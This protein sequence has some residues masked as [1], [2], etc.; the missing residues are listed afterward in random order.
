MMHRCAVRLLVFALL[1]VSLPLV[2]EERILSYDSDI[3]VGADGDMTVRETI[4]V[5]AEGKNIRRGIYREFPTTY[6]D[7]FGNTVKVRFQIVELTRDGQTEPWHKQRLSNGVRIYAGS[8]DTFLSPGEYTYAFTYTTNRQIGFFE[9]HDELYWNVTGNGWDFAIERASATVRLPG[10]IDAA[11]ITL[12]GYTGPQGSK[13]RNFVSA[14]ADSS[15]TIQTSRALPPRSGLTLVMGWPK[16]VVAQPGRLQQLLYLLGDNFGLLLSVL[17]FIG[18]AAYLFV[19]WS[20]HGRD[21]GKGVIFPHYEPPEGFSPAAARYVNEM[22]YDDETFTAA[23][24]NLAVKGYLTISCD[25]DDY[26]L[27]QQSSSEDLAPGESG[28]LNKLFRD[29]MV[30][31]L[32]NSNHTRISAARFAHKQA[33]RRDYLNHYFKTNGVLM[34]PSIVVSGLL[35]L[36]IVSTGSFVPWV[37]ACYAGVV[38]LHIAFAYLL[39][40]PSGRGRRLMDKLEGFKLYL[41]VAEKDDLD[42]RHPPDLTPELFE[43]YLPFAI[44]LGVEQKWAEQFSRVFARMEATS[45]GAYSPRWYHGSFNSSRMGSFASSVGSNLSSAVSSSAAAPGSSSGSG[46]GSSGGGGGGGG[47]GGW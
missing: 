26:T 1:F 29:G 9:D 25:D 8:S 35:L 39:K 46:G 32:K 16:G 37:L 21:P 10:S 23:V 44:A 11:D 18:S 41:E 22:G 36:V 20:T 47:G 14:V 34:L 27:Q 40:A 19:M 43:K 15:G 12:T 17:A 13:D 4:R 7:R 24:I 2:A 6:K 38:V 33:L 30:L 5:A 31:E 28:L 45:D 3:T 42:L